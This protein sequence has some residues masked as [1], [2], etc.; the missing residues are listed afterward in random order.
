MT[1]R[2]LLKFLQRWLGSKLDEQSTKVKARESQYTENVQKK[3]A[4]KPETSKKKP[5]PKVEE[6]EKKF[7]L[8]DGKE[9]Y[10]DD[11]EV[12]FWKK[13]TGRTEYLKPLNYDE[14]EK[15]GIRYG[16]PVFLSFQQF[17]T[18]Q[19]LI[20]LKNQYSLTYILANV[21]FVSAVILLQVLGILA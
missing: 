4:P 12:A 7:M 18:R 9:K 19:G 6:E 10:L 5:E 15:E 3:E 11:T 13:I 20:D 16:D 1:P 8:K 21:M 17:L 2:G 14:K